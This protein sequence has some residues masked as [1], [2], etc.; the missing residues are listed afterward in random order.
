MRLLHNQPK[1]KKSFKTFFYDRFRKFIHFL[2]IFS[3]LFDIYCVLIIT[4]TL[5]IDMSS[6]VDFLSK[7]LY[8]RI[9]NF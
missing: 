9:I 8:N 5:F 7:Q 1:V 4:I 6:P 2:H 3:F